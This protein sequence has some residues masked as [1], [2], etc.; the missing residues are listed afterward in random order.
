LPENTRPTILFDERAI[1]SGCTYTEEMHNTIDMQ[2]RRKEFKE[3]LEEYK[4]IARERGTIY[5][6]IIPISG[7]K[8]SHFQAHVLT[9]EFGMKPLY[10]SF[11]H[12]FNSRV[13]KRNLD[14][15]IAN[16]PGDLIRLTVNPASIRKI[17]RYTLEKCGD[18]TWHSHSGIF[19]LP[20][21]I[22]VRYN[23][24]LIIYGETGYGE[25]FG[26][27]RPEDKAEFSTW[28][29]QEHD[30]RGIKP[31]DVVEDPNNDI[32]LYDMAPYIFPSPEEIERVGVRGIYLGNYVKWDQRANTE[33]MIKEYNFAT[34][35]TP[36]ER[37]DNLFTKIDC[38]A[39]D[40]HDYLCY[41]KFGYGRGT[42]Y[43][44]YDVREGRISREEAI[45]IV[46]RYDHVRPSTLDTYLNF[47][48]LTEKEFEDAVEKFRDPAIWVKNGD[49]KWVAKDSIVNH[50]NDP[51]VDKYRLPLKNESYNLFNDNWEYPSHTQLEGQDFFFI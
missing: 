30:M 12:L 33:L 49:G 7:A 15:F 5:D 43:T 2:E 24:P 35:K 3:L 38:H 45:K 1:C 11:N 17:C 9:R 39:D 16:F 18:I 31:M 6:C 4:A 13:G 32:T 29:R 22:A 14:N 34:L 44:A 40:V 23:I 28:K 26:M 46:G 10:V 25:S 20:F 19:T 48:N 47:M 36:R 42:R 27:Y 8:D 51:D 21:Q 37:T 50:V 41:L